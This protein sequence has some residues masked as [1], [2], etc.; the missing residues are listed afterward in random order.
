MAKNL[1]SKLPS[2]DTLLIQDINLEAT[3]RFVE[4]IQLAS[5][6]ASVRVASSVREAAENSVSILSS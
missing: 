1:Q 2:T 5:T 4:E 3:S 6:G